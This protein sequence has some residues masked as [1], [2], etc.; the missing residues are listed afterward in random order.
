MKEDRALIPS[1]GGMEQN[2]KSSYSTHSSTSWDEPDFGIELLDA[3]VLPPSSAIGTTH[4]LVRRGAGKKPA[5]MMNIP[6]V[7]DIDVSK[8]RRHQHPH[9][10]RR[11]QRRN[12]PALDRIT[13]AASSDSD[14]FSFPLLATLGSRYQ[15]FR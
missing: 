5:A 11:R 14:S 1:T 4:G 15:L 2:D 3:N 12:A 10:H 7:D 8:R 6:I 9:Q 13:S